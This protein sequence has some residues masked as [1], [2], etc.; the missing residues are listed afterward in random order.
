MSSPRGAAVRADMASG[1]MVRAMLA[2]RD[3]SRSHGATPLAVLLGSLL[4]WSCA[5]VVDLEPVTYGEHPAPAGAMDADAAAE[6]EPV[7]PPPDSGEASSP[8]PVDP[9]A[10][11]VRDD[12]RLHCTNRANAPLRA[13]PKESASIVNTLRTTNSYFLCWG[14]GDRHA[15]GN[16]TWYYTIGDDN[17][18]LGWVAGVM[19]NTPDEIDANPSAYGLRNCSE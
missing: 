1:G 5:A 11:G 15:G 17:P 12:K 18:N 6:S 14:T 19:L 10:C 16:S 4:A 8:I 7:G 3:R 9:G 2:R 13:L